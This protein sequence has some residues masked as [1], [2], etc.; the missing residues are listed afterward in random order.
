MDEAALRALVVRYRAVQR[1][2]IAA[3]EDPAIVSPTIRAA[4]RTASEA[5]G[6]VL[7]ELEALLHARSTEE[8]AESNEGEK[9]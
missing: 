7:D 1:A 8:R 5:V 9:P 6:L 2:F 3:A 4:S